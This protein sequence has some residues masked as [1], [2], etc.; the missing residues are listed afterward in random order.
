MLK[1]IIPLVIVGIL[2]F[3]IFNYSKVAGK[4]SRDED[5][6]GS[7]PTVAQEVTNIVEHSKAFAPFEETD[8]S[9]PILVAGS[10]RYETGSIT[11]KGIVIGVERGVAI[12]ESPG[13]REYIRTAA[14]IP[15]RTSAVVVG[16]VS[17]NGKL[18]AVMLQD[19][20][21]IRVGTTLEEGYVAKLR[22]AAAELVR[23]DGGT[24]FVMFG[25]PVRISSNSAGESEE[26]VSA[27]QAIKPTSLIG[28]P[29]QSES[30]P[31][32]RRMEGWQ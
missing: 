29:G 10:D 25:D 3:A 7:S 8:K 24:H 9:L 17:E 11:S 20:R 13:N 30:V 2:A 31:A 15:T 5:D 4:F 28:L 1:V 23:P 32:V 26:I 21:A 22:P 19:G 6:K 14:T 16:R 27:G 12:V 18:L